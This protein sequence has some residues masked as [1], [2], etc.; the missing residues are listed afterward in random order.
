MNPIADYHMH[1]PLCGHAVGEPA[2]YAQ[3]AIAVG[4][5]EIGFSDHAPLVSHDDPTITMNMQ[6][7]P[8]YLKMIEAVRDQFSKK[9]HVKIA[10]EADYIPE[11]GRASC[12][13]RVCQY[14]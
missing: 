13:E 5:Q 11:I 7:L 4:L 3:H 2:V 10:L 9:L 14:V 6:Q 12:R 8:G 1:T